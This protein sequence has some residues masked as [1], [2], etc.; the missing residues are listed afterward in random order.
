MCEKMRFV[1]VFWPVAAELFGF[2]ERDG[3]CFVRNDMLYRSI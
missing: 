2:E 1:E 3:Y